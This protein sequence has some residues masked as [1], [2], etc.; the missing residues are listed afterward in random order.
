MIDVLQP[1]AGRQ[2]VGL[3]D[4]GIARFG[5]DTEGVAHGA[6]DDLQL[7]GILGRERDEHHEEA[8]HQAHQ[9]GE[10]HEPAVTASV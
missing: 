10:G 3:D 1:R 9:I 2:P 8:H 7:V 4:A 6:C 5:L